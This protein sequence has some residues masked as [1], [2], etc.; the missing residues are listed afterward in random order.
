MQEN[1]CQFLNIFLAQKHHFSSQESLFEIKHREVEF[2]RNNY[3][4]CTSY[5]FMHVQLRMLCFVKLPNKSAIWHKMNCWICITLQSISSPKGSFYLWK[6]DWDQSSYARAG[7]CV[8]KWPYEKS[9][10]IYGGNQCK[11]R[12]KSELPKLPIYNFAFIF[13]EYL[14]NLCMTNY[15]TGDR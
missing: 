15:F 5:I 14:H 10:G 12:T 7:G 4:L 8:E 1:Y 13:W 2:G 11:N 6:L 9:I 3:Q